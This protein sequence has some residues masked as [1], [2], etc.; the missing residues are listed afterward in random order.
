MSRSYPDLLV[1]YKS[2]QTR[3]LNKLPRIPQVLG[4]RYHLC[5]SYVFLLQ[6]FK[7][8]DA[9]V[10]KVFSA[11]EGKITYLWR[12]KRRIKYVFIEYVK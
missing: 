5:H 9:I 3:K 11:V 1:P 8:L 12:K 2:I 6:Y 10:P 7:V 4:V